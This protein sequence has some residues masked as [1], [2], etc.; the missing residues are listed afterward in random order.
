[1]SRAVQHNQVAQRFEWVEDGVPSELVYE[2]QN[3]V[4]SILHTGVPE[5]VGGRGI[6]ADLA[7]AALNTAVEQGWLVRPVCSY[8]A[9]YIQKNPQYQSLLA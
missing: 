4:M 5:A 2:L 6:A 9:A 1:M 3:G 7:Q 8:V